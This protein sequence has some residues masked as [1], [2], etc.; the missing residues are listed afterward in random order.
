M[1]NFA[2]NMVHA[3]RNRHKVQPVAHMFQRSR[4]EHICSANFWISHKSPRFFIS[5]LYITTDKP[6]KSGAIRYGGAELAIARSIAWRLRANIISNGVIR[7]RLRARFARDD[8]AGG[9]NIFCRCLWPLDAPMKT[10]IFTS[11]SSRFLLPLSIIRGYCLSS[12]NHVCH[13]MWQRVIYAR[14]RCFIELEML[15]PVCLCRIWNP[16]LLYLFVATI[17]FDQLGQ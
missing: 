3:G 7:V 2:R 5:S 12:K 4:Q 9:V 13:Q 8:Q 1:A 17:F 11:F 16:L 14:V 6:I 10:Q 15:Y